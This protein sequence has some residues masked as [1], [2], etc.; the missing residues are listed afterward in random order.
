MLIAQITDTHLTENGTLAQNA[1]DTLPKMEAVIASINGLKVQP[2]VVLIT[3]DLADDEHPDGYAQLARLRGELAPPS[4]VIPGNHDNRLLM[5]KHFSELP[6]GGMEPIQYAI[7]DF[8]VRIVGI[9]TVMPGFDRGELCQDRLDWLENCLAKESDKPT[10]IMMHHPPFRTYI[11]ELDEFGIDTG[12]ERFEQ[13][14]LKNPQ[15]VRIIC[16]H[17]H[18]SIQT[19][20][21]NRLCS[22]A[23]AVSFDQAL[24]LGPDGIKGFHFG[25]PRYELHQFTGTGFVSHTVTRDDLT[26]PFQYLAEGK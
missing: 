25:S 19:V 13:I 4:F 9:D 18:R 21:A 22:I 8:D 1:V 2:D 26:P 16:G 6:G 10:L 12:L 23:P 11:D 24:G 3:G 7:E 15:I 5:R 20:F 14:V 17:V